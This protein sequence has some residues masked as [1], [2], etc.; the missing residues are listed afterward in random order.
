MNKA[1]IIEYLSKK[2]KYSKEQLELIEAIDEAREE[3]NIT[4][5]YFESVNDPQLVDYA[6][7]KEEA[8]KARLS[9]LLKQ[10]KEKG[11]RVDAS[12]ML[13]EMEAV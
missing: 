8:A 4:R 6:I 7:Y 10:A 12:L 13:D 5:Q 1:G 9:Y 11:I 3:L 2:L